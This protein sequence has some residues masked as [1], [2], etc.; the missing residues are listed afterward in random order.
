[1]AEGSGGARTRGADGP[2]SELIGLA[3]TWPP[4]RRLLAGAVITAML[5]TGL[6]IVP[7]FTRVALAA[8]TATGP[9]LGIAARF[10]ASGYL[11]DDG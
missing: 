8:L 4:R 11:D 3:A 6:E 10:A 5:Y 9:R 7:P 1:M 2:L